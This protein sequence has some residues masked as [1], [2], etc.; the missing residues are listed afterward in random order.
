MKK[1]HSIS[2]LCPFYLW[3]QFINCRG[4]TILIVMSG[5]FICYGKAGRGGVGH[6]YTAADILQHVYVIVPIAECGNLKGCEP[7]CP[8]N[9]L[10]TGVFSAALIGDFQQMWDRRGDIAIGKFLLESE[11]KC[12]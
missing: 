3:N 6:S 1:G 5:D 7:Q 10:H 9:D 2:L 4:D 12:P 11:T 8:C